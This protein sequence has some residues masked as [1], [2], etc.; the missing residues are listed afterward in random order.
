MRK[1][2]LSLAVLGLVTAAVI[3]YFIK[4]DHEPDALTLLKEKYSQKDSLSV[5]HSQFAVLKQKFTSPQQVTE[6]CISCHNKRHTEIMQSNH[7]NWEREEY[8]PGR[9]IVYLGKKNA[10]N[11]YCIG[12]TGNEASCAKCHIGFENKDKLTLTNAANVDC[13]VCHDNT[14]TYV[15]ANEEGGAPAA[16]L[17]LNK[18]AQS[19]NKPNRANCGVCHFYGGGGNNVKHG[20]L[21]MVMF[22]TTR[23]IDVH[24]GTDGANLVCIDCHVTEKHN[25]SGKLYSLSSMNQNRSNC[26]QCHSSQP[27]ED[28][29]LNEH[30]V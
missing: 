16:S 29:I 5:D 28:G 9:G 22:S 10:I 25:I 2:I 15:K 4:N 27:H 23:D 24:M 12:A 18:I 21:D 6:A 13:L 8:V 14:E 17:D 26:E 30:T 1:I 3:G 7:W 11:N 19:V 20:D